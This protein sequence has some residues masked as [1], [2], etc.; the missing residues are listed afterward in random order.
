MTARAQSSK[1]MTY[2]KLSHTKWECKYHILFIPKYRKKVIYGTI[3]KYL[4]DVFHEL[5]FRKE[6]RIEEGYLMKDHVHMLISI[7]PKYQLSQIVGYLKGK[8]AIYISQKSAHRKNSA[9][10]HF[11]A[12]GYFVSTV[13]FS[14]KGVIP[15]PIFR[16]GM[17]C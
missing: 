7:P 3:K 16:W 15:F 17:V 13:G 9:G 4:K 6:C 8:T 10:Y 14:E 12:K 1:S 11:W 2:N 5:A